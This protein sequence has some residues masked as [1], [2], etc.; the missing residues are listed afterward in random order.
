MKSRKRTVFAVIFII[1]MPY[2]CMSYELL[3]SKNKKGLVLFIIVM[4]YI[5]IFCCCYPQQ[6]RAG[7][8]YHCNVL[9]IYIWIAA[10]QKIRKG[11]FY[12][13]F[14]HNSKEGIN[15]SWN[16]I[17]FILTR[18]KLS[19]ACVV[20]LLMPCHLMQ[21]SMHGNC[22]LDFWHTARIWR[23]LAVPLRQLGDLFSM[24]S[25]ILIGTS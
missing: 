5:Y 9:Y 25:R 2:I 13:S 18:C 10:L 19:I 17:I 3:P 14:I 7:S 11:W 8:I 4:S 24:T 1:V 12:L 23:H 16:I 22:F 15:W 20:G 21:S 6:I